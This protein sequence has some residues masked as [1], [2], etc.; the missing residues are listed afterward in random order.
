MATD[1]SV[2]FED[3]S[4]DAQYAV[5]FRKET[6][7]CN[8]C[9]IRFSRTLREIAWIMGVPGVR[10]TIPS[11]AILFCGV[12]CREVWL[13]ASVLEGKDVGRRWA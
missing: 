3:L 10:R 6:G 9:D 8:L 13:A 11:A 7:W 1:P 12:T 4:K 5:E 2:H